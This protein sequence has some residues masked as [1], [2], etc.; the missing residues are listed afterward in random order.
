MLRIYS[1]DNITWSSVEKDVSYYK[2]IWSTDRN[3][4]PTYKLLNEKDKRIDISDYIQ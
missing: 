2:V 4:I 3:G 1:E